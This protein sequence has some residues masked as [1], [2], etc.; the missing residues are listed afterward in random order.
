LK[1]TKAIQQPH[2]NKKLLSLALPQNTVKLLEVFA[3]SSDPRHLNGFIAELKVI[4]LYLKR[5]FSLKSH[6]KE[7]F[8][9]EVDIVMESSSKI[10]L[11]EVKYVTHMDFAFHR[12]ALAQKKRLENVFLRFIQWTP[13]EVEFHY[14]ICS[15][16]RFHVF[17]DFLSG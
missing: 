15:L 1:N 2:I 16:E 4:R 8:K 12:M 5:G 13:K 9:T 7:Y 3:N 6:R 10:I 17:E 14:V 11:I